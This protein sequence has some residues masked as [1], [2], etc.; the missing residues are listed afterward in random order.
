M[1]C[2]VCRRRIR[3]RVHRWNYRPFCLKCY[4]YFTRRVRIS[5][6]VP[7][8]PERPGGLFRRLFGP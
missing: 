8:P 4:Q 5:R 6:T 7:K 1:F 2:N 3:G